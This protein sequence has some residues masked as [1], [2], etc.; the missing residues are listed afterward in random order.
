M[1]IN[2][3]TV[4][5]TNFNK[6]DKEIVKALEDFYKTWYNIRVNY[7]P[8]IRKIKIN[9][10]GGVKI[11]NNHDGF[12]ALE[13]VDGNTIVNNS[14]SKGMIRGKVEEENIE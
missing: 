13:V 2:K 3:T 1:N 10:S 9:F 6:G 14:V 12:K 7:D 11:E 4:S 8:S 5:T